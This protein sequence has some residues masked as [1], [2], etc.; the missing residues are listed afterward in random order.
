M[1]EPGPARL[2][3]DIR[4]PG[5]DGAFIDG[6]PVIGNDAFGGNGEALAEPVAHLTHAL[7][8]IEGKMLGRG[9]RERNPTTGCVLAKHSVLL[10]LA[11]DDQRALAQ[12]QRVLGGLGDARQLA[13]PRR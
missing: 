5:R 4:P 3:A 11:G 7:W 2:L 10:A 9:R 1:A 12:A 8:A 13:R 6:Q